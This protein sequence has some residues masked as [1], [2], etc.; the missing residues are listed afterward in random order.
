MWDGLALP[1]IAYDAKEK[2]GFIPLYL[3]QPVMYA[4]YVQEGKGKI[5]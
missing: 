5:R 4:M 2:T 3:L 1:K